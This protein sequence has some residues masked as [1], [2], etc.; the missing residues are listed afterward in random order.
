M[1][2]RLGLKSI[3]LLMKTY[4][5][6]PLDSV[7][8]RV[9]GRKAEPAKTAEKKGL[10][11]LSFSRIREKLLSRCFNMPQSTTCLYSRK[12]NKDKKQIKLLRQIV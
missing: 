9:A 12:N 7:E 5:T 10:A 2:H 8:V 4:K 1:E 11:F 6:Y 3:I